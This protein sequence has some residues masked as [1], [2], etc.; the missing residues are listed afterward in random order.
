[1]IIFASEN[2]LNFKR[3]GKGTCFENYERSRKA[4]GCR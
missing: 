1:M 2:D 4:S 3:Y